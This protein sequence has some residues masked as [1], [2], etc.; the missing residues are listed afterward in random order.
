MPAVAYA[1]DFFLEGGIFGRRKSQSTMDCVEGNH[2][3]DAVFPAEPE[4]QETW[5]C[6]NATTPNPNLGQGGLEWVVYLSEEGAA[7]REP[8]GQPAPGPQETMPDPCEG[9]PSDP[10]CP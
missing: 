7:I 1:G 10:R 3:A 9:V 2:F 6:Q 5:G 4:L 8:K